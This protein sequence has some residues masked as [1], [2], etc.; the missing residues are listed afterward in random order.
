MSAKGGKALKSVLHQ[1]GDQR[2]TVELLGYVE[3]SAVIGQC[4]LKCS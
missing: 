3:G 1:V 2:R 4:D